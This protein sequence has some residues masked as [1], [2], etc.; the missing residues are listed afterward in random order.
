MRC[1]VC[2]IGGLLASAASAAPGTLTL[3]YGSPASVTMTQGMPVGNGRLGGLVPG[4]VAAESI[5]LTESSLWAGTANLSGGYDTGPTGAFGGFQL[6]GNLLL[7]LPSHTGYGAYQRTLDLSTGIGT[8]DY[9]SNGVTY[10]REIFCSAPDQVM[11]IRLS[12]DAAAAYTGSLQLTDGRPNTSVSTAGGLMF[13]AALANGEAYEAQLQVINDGGTLTRSGG[14]IQFSN[15]NSLTLVV[16]LGT[17]Y[18]MDYSRNYRG[19]HPHATVLAQAQAAVAKDYATLK[20]A[21]TTD[22]SALFNRV[23]LN[24]GPPPAGR[25]EL[26][27]DQ[28]IAANA[29]SGDD[30]GMVQLMFQYGRYVLI[31]SSRTGCP[32]NLQGLWTDNNNAAWGAD[33]HTDFNISMMYWQAEVANLS[34]CLQPFINLVQSQLPAW[35]YVTTNT[36]PSINN[37]GY[38]GGLGGTRGWSLRI[39]H[40]IWGGMGWHWNQSANAWYCNHLWDHYAFTGDVEYLRTTAYPILK[41]VCEFWQD[42]LKALPVATNGAPAGTLVAP[43]GWSPEAGPWEDGVT[44]DQIWIWDL[45]T[46]YRRACAILNTDAAYAATIASLQDHLLKPRIGP[47]GQIREWFY[48]ADDPASFAMP[49]QLLS[50]YPAWQLTPEQDPALAAAAHF[51]LDHRNQMNVSPGN[52]DSELGGPWETAIYARLH[53]AESAFRKVACYGRWTNP[54]LSGNVDN[55]PV[56]DGPCCITAGI[57]E[58][59][60]QSHSGAIELLPALPKAWPTGAVTGL[61]AR[62]GYTVDLAWTNSGADPSTATVRCAFGGVCQLRTPAT[63]TISRGGVPV[64]VTRLSV[65]EMSCTVNSGDVLLVTWTQPAVAATNP[66][67]TDGGLGAVSNAVLTWTSGGVAY[68]HDV[69]LGTSHAAVTSATPQ[70]AEFRGRVAVPSL[71]LPALQPGTTYFWR[72]DEVASPTQFATGA[73]WSFTTPRGVTLFWD[74]NS[75]VA[76]RRS[77]NPTTTAQTW[78]DGGNWDD[79]ATSTAL[80]SWQPGDAAV[81]SGSAASQTVAADSLT[82]GNLTFGQGPLGEGTSGTSYT[83]IGG[84]LTLARLVIT[85]NTSATI[86]ST[87]AGTDGLVKAG[88]G[89]L[90]LTANNPFTGGTLVDAGTLSLS[91]I[92]GV[93]DKSQLLGTLTINPGA[94]LDLA[95]MPFGYGGGLTSLNVNGGTVNTASGGLGMFGVIYNLTTATI[96]GSGRVDLGS[97]NSIN[98]AINSRASAS[99]S[100]ISN[101]NSLGLMLRGDSGQQAYVFTT[102]KG[103]TA[104][105]ID[106]QLP[107]ITENAGPCSVVKTGTGTLLLAGGGSY[108]G[109]TTVSSGTLVVSGSLGASTVEVLVGATLAVNGSLGSSL[110]L[111]SGGHLALSVAATPVAQ[112]T[113]TIAGPLTFDAGSVLDLTAAALPAVGTYVLANVAGVITGTPTTVNCSGLAGT[114]AVNG[115]RLELTV[116]NGY[117]L[118][119]VTHGSAGEPATSDFDHD[120][121]SNLMEYVLQGGDPSAPSTAILP[122]SVD[123]ATDL[124]FTYYRRAAATGTTQVFQYGSDLSTWTDVPVTAGGV[125]AITQNNPVEGIDR[126]VITISKDTNTK[127]FGRLKVTK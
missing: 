119:A 59:L 62:G 121:L 104:S 46:N 64:D 74:G 36:S 57:A 40:N 9:T 44:Y 91:A 79:G 16:A 1:L 35:R 58:M 70:S 94:S 56:W 17:D 80:A 7:N 11:V 84:T 76:N 106:L 116:R 73:V 126:V 28:R 117:E 18:V 120:G 81:F 118:W 102:E 52:N 34:E 75:A 123:T 53:D 67:P 85:T 55:F 98:G 72:V 49:L 50:V 88:A 68:Q 23:S 124:V 51:T 100:V 3:W 112:T 31:S 92:N 21:H 15:C 2:L 8:V 101:T 20:S 107:I 38:G 6:F 113:R 54:N 122:T 87:L 27:T 69:Y 89:T 97:R 61:R 26:P 109:A 86:S 47:W 93:F 60:V 42:R 105:G 45:F 63:A 127:L 4:K 71:T 103:T 43:N 66:N 32:A 10:H 37:G 48:T 115:H 114:V 22:F 77:D 39:S 24:L 82:V 90:T 111:R 19:S 108:T 65:T 41:E 83:I 29:A 30:P 99:P 25:A 110:A 78:L 95:G 13:A 14:V 96:G 12:A 33:Y 5:A 125:V